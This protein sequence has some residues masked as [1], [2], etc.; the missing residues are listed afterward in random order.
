M[1]FSSNGYFSILG[2]LMMMWQS[3]LRLPGMHKEVEDDIDEQWELGGQPLFGG[4]HR[5]QSHAE[6]RA[7]FHAPLHCITAM[8]NICFSPVVLGMMS[9]RR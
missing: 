6:N 9:Y 2:L 1:L 4:T 5:L 3:V 7:I 8:F